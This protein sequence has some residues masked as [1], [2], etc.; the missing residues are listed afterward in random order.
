MNPVNFMT[1]Q[2]MLAQRLAG[3]P[4]QQPSPDQAGDPSLAPAQPAQ[5]SLDYGQFTDAEQQNALGDRLMAGAGSGPVRTGW[6]GAGRLGKMLSGALLKGSASRSEKEYTKK[7]SDYLSSAFN[8]D[9]SKVG[10]A[11]IS[12][13]DP[14]LQELGL[15]FKI[16]QAQREAARAE[17]ET[18][19]MTPA[20]RLAHDDRVASRDTSATQFRDT[21]TAA[22]RRQE[23]ALGAQA[24]Q[25]EL[26]RANAIKAAATRVGSNGKLVQSTIQLSDGRLMRQ[27][28]DGTSEIITLPPTEVG[29]KGEDAKGQNDPEAKARN[30]AAAGFGKS[31][32]TQ[33]EAEPALDTTF[34]NIK[35]SLAAL[36]DPAV[37]KQAKYALGVASISPKLPGI[38]SDFLSRLEQI[39][40]Q[41]F[42][43]AFSSLKGGGAITEVEGTKATNAMAR[44]QRAQTETEFYKAKAETEK[45]L[46][47]IYKSAKTRAARGKA[48]LPKSFGLSETPVAVAPPAAPPVAPDHAALLKKYGVE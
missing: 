40:G 45:T 42:L 44:L 37:R 4:F 21:Q 38:N 39:Q 29:G 8:G 47:E 26:N 17:K 36:D 41:T 19:P 30:A 31:A 23:K 16:S 25:N 27:Y 14:K 20:E 32:A 2:Q 10:E 48:L 1:P 34:N 28:R 3:V 13:G 12:S 46:E 24:T 9:S 5:P 15:S 6:E 22:D 33:A 18:E 35:T 7:R 11:L 43:Q